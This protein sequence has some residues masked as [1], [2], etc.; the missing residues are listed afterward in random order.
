MIRTLITAPYELARLPLV[1]ADQ[2]LGAR[3]SETSPVRVTLDR[4]IGSA[5]KVAGAVLG[6]RDI[7]RRGADRIE[8]SDKVLTAK[9]LEQEAAARREQARDT[10]VSGRRQ[11]AEKRRAAQ[12]RAVSGLEE[13]DVAEARGKQQAKASAA[14]TASAKK[15][16][17]AK[18]AQDKLTTVQQRKKAVD[19][20]AQAKKRAAQR[21]VEPDI[22]EARETGQSAEQARADAER[23]H[24]LTQAKKQD[25]KEG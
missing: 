16:A 3:L 24:D 19:T 2:H 20:A 13:A 25:R 7:A 12:A 6:D 14:K 4:A 22:A 17:A 18:R 10:A 21:R 1:L 11:A 5:D 23:L 8:Q 15:A 9:R